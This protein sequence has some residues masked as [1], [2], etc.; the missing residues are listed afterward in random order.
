MSNILTIKVDDNR[1]LAAITVLE[2]YL[3]GAVPDMINGDVE[4]KDFVLDVIYIHKALTKV[5]SPFSYLHE[6]K[7]EKM[8][9]EASK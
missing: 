9:K 4:N 3:D 6:N 7:Y 8:L 2:N 5:N 1:T